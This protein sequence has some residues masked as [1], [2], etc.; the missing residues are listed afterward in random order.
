MVAGGSS[1][2]FLEVGQATVKEAAINAVCVWS[3]GASPANI[4]LTDTRVNVT[5]NGSSWVTWTTGSTGSCSSPSSDSKVY[6]YMSLDSTVGDRCLLASPSCQLTFNNVVNG[7]GNKLSPENDTD[8]GVL[9]AGVAS[10][11]N[12]QRMNVAGTDIRPEDAKF[13]T[14]R[15][16][17]DCGVPVNGVSGSQYLGLGYAVS[18]GSHIGN[19][20]VQSVETGSGGNSV[21]FNVFDFNLIGNDPI[22]NAPVATYTVSD[23]GAVP[24]VVFVNPSDQSG[25]GSLQASNVT[26]QVLAGYLDGTYGWTSDL[27]GQAYTGGSGATTTVFIREP[28]S[29]TYNTME[30]AIPNSVE[31]KTSQDVSY[32]SN[33]ATGNN[34]DPLMPNCSA[35]PSFGNP[36]ST[37]R[38]AQ[39]EDAIA[40]RQG[41]NTSSRFRAIGTGDMVAAVLANQDSLGYSFWGTGNFKN[42]IAINGKYLTVD[43][44]DPLQ[45]VWSDGLIPTA[46]NGLLGNVSFANV[47]NGGYPIWSKLRLAAIGTG[48]AVAAQLATVAQNYVGPTQPDFVPVSQLSVVRSH[49][50]PPFNPSSNYSAS[51]LSSGTNVPANHAAFNGAVACTGAAAEAGGDVGGTVLTIQSDGD[52]CLEIGGNT[53]N[54]GHRQ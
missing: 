27:V 6:F 30:Y 19:P 13:A 17:T 47:K 39:L 42:A 46:K 40:N 49:F 28:L 4:Y 31:L 26:R 36:G 50:A 3:A 24:V 45:Q 25:F 23:V 53:G 12:G 11:L 14:I 52:Y 44:Q 10:A 20:I 2:L 7:G 37:V 22:S 1:A 5:E 8:S 38:E 43:G 15:A 48:E 29:G 35:S 33:H 21:A 16:L 18:P 51:F 41:G 32:V 9:P 34:P 54:T